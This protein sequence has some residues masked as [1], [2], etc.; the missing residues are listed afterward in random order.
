MRQAVCFCNWSDEGAGILVGPFA[1]DYTS[2]ARIQ[3]GCHQVT[4]EVLDD[5]C[6]LPYVA[7]PSGS[8]EVVAIT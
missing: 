3:V 6:S 1:L 2:V 8:A 4:A 7:A 5:L